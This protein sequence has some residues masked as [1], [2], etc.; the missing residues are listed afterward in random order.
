MFKNSI[1]EAAFCKVLNTYIAEFGARN[2][3]LH[4]PRVVAD[5]LDKE[6]ISQL[7]IRFWKKNEYGITTRDTTANF[8]FKPQD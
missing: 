4:L 1:D 3:I 6:V 7:T 2:V 5:S 8:T